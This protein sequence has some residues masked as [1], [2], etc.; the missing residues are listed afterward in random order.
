MAVTALGGE[1][2]QA[3]LSKAIRSLKDLVVRRYWA[4]SFEFGF[5]ESFGGRTKR[6]PAMG[7][8]RRLRTIT[9]ML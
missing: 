2:P 3:A 1:N 7:R 5:K 8:R 6:E 9:S 4:W